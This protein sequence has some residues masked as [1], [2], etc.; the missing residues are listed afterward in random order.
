MC[1]IDADCKQFREPED[2]ESFDQRND[3][4]IMHAK[5][6]SIMRMKGAPVTSP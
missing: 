3:S 5:D 2:Q 1:L 4:S 6:L